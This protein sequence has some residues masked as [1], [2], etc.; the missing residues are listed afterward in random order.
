VRSH[1]KKEGKA[2]G[3]RHHWGDCPRVLVIVRYEKGGKR[4]E[5]LEFR[6]RGSGVGERC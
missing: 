6:V 5:N 1:D 2:D 3:F 4:D